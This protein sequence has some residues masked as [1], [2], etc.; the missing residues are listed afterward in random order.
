MSYHKIAEEYYYV[1]SGRGTAILNGTPYPLEMGDFLR[2]LPAPPTAS[3]PGR[4]RSSCWTST[5][6][7]PGQIG[8]CTLWATPPLASPFPLLHDR[9]SFACLP[10]PRVY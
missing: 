6:P 5:P 8:M 1:L 9:L 3:S 10:G 2:L 7:A 4:S